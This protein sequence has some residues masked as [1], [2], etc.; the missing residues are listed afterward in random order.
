MKQYAVKLVRLYLLIF[1]KKFLRLAA[2]RKHINSIA[3]WNNPPLR[4]G[5]LRGDLSGNAE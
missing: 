4:I 2:L 1:K 3:S 5:L